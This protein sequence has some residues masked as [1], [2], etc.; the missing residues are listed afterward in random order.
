MIVEKFTKEETFTLHRHTPDEMPDHNGRLPDGTEGPVGKPLGTWFS[1]PGGNPSWDEWCIGEGFLTESLSYK[2][3]FEVDLAKVLHI[4][5][6]E[7]IVEFHE[8]YKQAWDLGF[9]TERFNIR[10]RDVAY[11]HH[12][13]II[14][15]YFW[16]CRLGRWDSDGRDVTHEISNWYYGWDCASGVIWEPG[17]VRHI[18]TV[19]N[20]WQRQPRPLILES[21]E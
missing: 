4:H 10:W 20:D 16:S 3:T 11:D 13:I 15:P 18:E 12:G 19:E 6:F 7:Q 17:A 2:H 8:R 9:R 14:A 5:T 1:V 21:E